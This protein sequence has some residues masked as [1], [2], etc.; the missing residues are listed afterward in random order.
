[1]EPTAGLDSGDSDVDTPGEAAHFTD[2]T[3]A[4]EADAE[5]ALK[6]A[7]AVDIPEGAE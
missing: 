2:G 3:L 4:S 6:V 7:V 1:M 5:D